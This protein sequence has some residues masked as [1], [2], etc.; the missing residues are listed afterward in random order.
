MFVTEVLSP[1]TPA[2]KSVAPERLRLYAT[3]ASYFLPTF[4]MN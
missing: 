3:S 1:G 4:K 2:F